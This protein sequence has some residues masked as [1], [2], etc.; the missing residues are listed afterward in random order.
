MTSLPIALAL[1]GGCNCGC[2]CSRPM[3]SAIKSTPIL[4]H[5][6][7][8]GKDDV[9]PQGISRKEWEDWAQFNAYWAN[10]DRRMKERGEQLRVVNGREVLFR[11]GMPVD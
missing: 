6:W 4:P 10:V 2:P 7:P 9:S 1:L 3:P 5:P 11:N 8:S